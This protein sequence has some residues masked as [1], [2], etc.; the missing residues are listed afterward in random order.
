MK[1]SK[2]KAFLFVSVLLRLFSTYSMNADNNVN[3]E[4]IDHNIYLQQQIQNFTD[5][6]GYLDRIEGIKEEAKELLKQYICEHSL[7]DSL[8][9]CYVMNE[10]KKMPV[11]HNQ[12]D[13]IYSLFGVKTDVD[14]DNKFFERLSS[15]AMLFSM[16][17][18]ANTLLRKNKLIVNGSEEEDAL[19]LLMQKALKSS[20]KA[21][22]YVKT[23]FLIE[24][25]MALINPPDKYKGR[26]GCPLILAAQ[27]GFI[28]LATLL[29]AK[30]AQ[31]DIRGVG[32]TTALITATEQEN[33]E[34][35]QLLLSHGASVNKKT[36]NKTTPLIYAAIK[37]NLSIV[38]LLLEAKAD[39]TVRDFYYGRTPFMAAAERGNEDIVTLLLNHVSI[40]DKKKPDWMGFILAAGKGH[41][42]IVQHLISMG[43]DINSQTPLG[44][45]AL[46][47]AAYN[48]KKEMVELLLKL[49]ADCSLKSNNKETAYSLAKQKGHEEIAALVKIMKNN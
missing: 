25:D 13:F 4:L 19:A 9:I 3:L 46:M 37:G 42:K 7:N 11:I 29:L 18:M 24:E 49:G 31:V 40:F 43:L 45:T 44:W 15:R 32:N 20:I 33:E 16:P 38:Q 28:S 39:V 36:S 41:C 47:S 34:M 35:V 8:R 17:I 27:H 14:L 2:I 26:G 5:K 12:K 10:L 1:I 30:G 48:G 23:V 21:N 6:P 22:D